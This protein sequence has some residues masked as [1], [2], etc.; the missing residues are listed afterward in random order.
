M[1]ILYLPTAPSLW[2][3]ELRLKGSKERKDIHHETLPTMWR[4][5]HNAMGRR[6][7]HPVQT[8]TRCPNSILHR[9]RNPT[10]NHRLKRNPAKS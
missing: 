5:D 10:G 2:S 8:H 4:T 9:G 1:V 3:S 6:A 7:V